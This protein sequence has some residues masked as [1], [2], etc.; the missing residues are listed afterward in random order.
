MELSKSAII[1]IP[2]HG[3]TEF[4]ATGQ[5]KVES[6][7]VYLFDIT[8]E[9]KTV[10]LSTI[11]GLP[12]LP[13]TKI[14]LLKPTSKVRVG[15]HDGTEYELRGPAEY[16]YYDLGKVMPKYSVSIPQSNDWYYSKLYS[17][18]G[19]NESAHA[20]LT[21]L[22]PQLQ[23][24]KEGPIVEFPTNYKIP[25]YVKDTVN[26]KKYIGDVSGVSDVFVD[27]DPTNDRDGNKIT[28]DD[29]DSDSASTGSG[30]VK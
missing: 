23:A 21:L 26:L 16:G 29:R 30:I 25:V 3:N 22:S 1:E 9:T 8:T 27:V 19:K 17:F 2:K 14:L 13:E 5:F 24:D 18:D 7:T 15:Y 12:V 6:G 4:L 20:S 11:K 28:N 10:E